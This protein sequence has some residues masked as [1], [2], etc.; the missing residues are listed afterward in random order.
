MLNVIGFLTIIKRICL[1]NDISKYY[2]SQGFI[3]QN[4]KLLNF[5][6][7]NGMTLDD[8]HKEFEVLAKVAHEAGADFVTM[9]RMERKRK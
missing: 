9:E 7:T 2:A 4:K 3:A 5:R 1:S 6:Q 8:Y